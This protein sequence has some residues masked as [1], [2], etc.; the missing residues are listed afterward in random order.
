MITFPIAH[1]P[2]DT[3]AKNELADLSVGSQCFAG[4][5][6]REPLAQSTQKAVSALLE[7]SS[8]CKNVVG[9][10]MLS[11]IA[12]WVLMKMLCIDCA[13]IKCTLHGTLP[14]VYTCAQV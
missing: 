14:D 8:S 2:S 3:C 4:G 9:A 7:S 6:A 12:R 5:A 13:I 11:S 1:R 10:R